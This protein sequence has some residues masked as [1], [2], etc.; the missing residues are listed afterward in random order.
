VYPN[1]LVSDH[2]PCVVSIE[3]KIPHAKLFRFESYWLLHPGF[4]DVVKK[5]W[6]RPVNS[7]NATMIL[8]R[9]FKSLRQELKVWSK[10]ISRLSVAIENTNKTLT[11][12]DDLENLRSLT[13]P[14]CNFRKII[15]K[16]LLRLLDYQKYYWKK[17]CTICWVKFG[18]ENTK[19]FQAVATERYRKNNVAILQT[20][21]GLMVEDHTGKEAL[22]FHAYTERLG[23]SNPTQMRFD[24]PSLIRPTENLDHLT[25]PFTQEEIDLVVKE[26]PVDRAPGPDGFSGLFLKAWWQI[27]KEDFYTL[28]AQ[29]HVGDLDL[30]SINDGLIT[31]IP[32]N[33]SPTTI[34]DYRPI[35]LLNCC[36][37]LITKLL[38]NHLQN[39]ILRIIHRNQ[40]GFIKGR[41]IQDCLAWTFQYIHECQASK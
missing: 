2:T 37:K 10:N 13:L 16:Y 32:K 11:E 5:V 20:P 33:G 38:S 12:L 4:M 24:L 3:T 6:D 26:M 19:F 8:C 29:F 36:L 35:T 31:L 17:R 21:E 14:E 40:Y 28:C 18:D 25:V 23:T 22:L 30:Q 7:S 34:N 41:S 15:K 39:V 1:T 9:K 27:M